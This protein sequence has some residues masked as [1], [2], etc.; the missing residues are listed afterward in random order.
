MDKDRVLTTSEFA[1]RVGVQPSFVTRL[2]NEGRIPEAVR[3]PQDGRYRIPDRRCVIP[4][5]FRHQRGKINEFYFR[6]YEIPEEWVENPD[7]RP[8]PGWVLKGDES[9]P[10]GKR[11]EKTFDV[12]VGPR[13]YNS[14]LYGDAEPWEE[15]E[16]HSASQDDGPPREFTQ[17]PANTLLALSGSE[18]GMSKWWIESTQNKSIGIDLDAWAKDERLKKIINAKELK[19]IGIDLDKLIKSEV[20]RGLVLLYR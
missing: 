7:S 18:A 4:S 15:R 13:E 3:D 20:L 16:S 2:I 19:D 9:E 14:T 1:R 12:K 6:P 10:L 17:L 8:G 11:I 5:K